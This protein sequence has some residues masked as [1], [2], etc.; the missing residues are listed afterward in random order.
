MV[1]LPSSRDVL[2]CC[3]EHPLPEL[4]LAPPADI[5][6]QLTATRV[7]LVPPSFE[8][9]VEQRRSSRRIAPLVYSNA[10]ALGVSAV[11]ASPSVMELRAA[12]V[13][14][15][16]RLAAQ[17]SPPAS[18]APAS[19]ARSAEIPPEPVCLPV[20]ISRAPT[21]AP[22]AIKTWVAAITAAFVFGAVS[23]VAVELVRHYTLWHLRSEPPNA[24]QMWGA[25]HLQSERGKSDEGRSVVQGSR[26]SVRIQPRRSPPRDHG[27]N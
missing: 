9:G 14:R 10:D 25:E 26:T 20:P 24:I 6:A 3:G 11:V 2:Q 17:K 27:P 15:Q 18:Q 1:P 8:S 13:E 4:Y 5:E 19:S 21:K 12:A 16:A 23:N 7:D 22:I